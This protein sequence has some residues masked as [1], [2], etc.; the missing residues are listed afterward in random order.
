MQTV[1]RSSWCAHENRKAKVDGETSLYHRLEPVSAFIDPVGINLPNLLVIDHLL[2]LSAPLER[3]RHRDTSPKV[4]SVTMV[5][6]TCFW[7]GA[8][9][10]ENVP[11]KTRPPQLLASGQCVQSC[12]IAQVLP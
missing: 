7:H 12:Q 4:W 1:L 10:V 3:S 6:L 9:P 5:C 11:S 2:K 8:W